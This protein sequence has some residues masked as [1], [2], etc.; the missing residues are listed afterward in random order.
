MKIASENKKPIDWELYLTGLISL[1]NFTGFFPSFSGIFFTQLN[2][3]LFKIFLTDS[4]IFL[5]G[6]TGQQEA[7]VLDGASYF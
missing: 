5:L 6:T 1:F 2:P 7:P 3:L 4:Y